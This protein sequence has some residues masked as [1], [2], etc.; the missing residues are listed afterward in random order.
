MLWPYI[1]TQTGLALVWLATIGILTQYFLNMEI[2]RY[3]L[4]TGETA[5]TGFTRLWK[6]WGWLFIIMAVVPWMWPG[7]AT[8]SSTAL[9][10]AFG[11]SEGM[12]V[13]ITIITLILIGIVL[14]VSPVVYQTVEKIQFFLVALILLFML[15]MIFGL[16]SGESWAALLSGFTAEIP[17]IPSA[18]GTIPTALLLGAIAFAGAGGVMNLAQSNWV[19]D[20]GMGMGAH[21]P[22]IVSPITGQETTSASIG[23]FFPQ[24]SEN[25]N[26]WKGW[27]RVAD[28]EQFI[29]FFIL[30]L[31]AIMLFMML[32]FTYVGVGSTAQNFD[33]VRLLGESLNLKV[34]TW[35][36]PAFWF[37][38]VVVLLSTNLTVVDMIGRIVADIVKT[39]WLRDSQAWTES[40]LYLTIVWLMVIFGSVIL[41]AGVNQPLLLL[42]IASA[43]NGLV[44]FVYSVLLI[45]LNRGMLPKAIGLGG[46]RYAAVIWAVI[47]YGGFSIY[48]I[49][50]QFGRLF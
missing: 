38:G 14:T 9:T 27:W 20:K 50:N 35:A 22:K 42:V 47:F 25:M 30:G 13:P 29:T 12:V 41:L 48:L 15:Y 19:R 6:H 44:M 33:F 16:L 34:G 1:A 45:K 18:I 39:N 28:R 43:L 10:Y 46:V 11:L 2:T 31:L 21:L 23:Y 36:G 5:V 7:W 17:D 49:I 37:I 32:S 8:G 24:N 4:A 40:R 26:R 3:T